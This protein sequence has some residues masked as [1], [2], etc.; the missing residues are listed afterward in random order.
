MDPAD[1]T[2]QTQP[3]QTLEDLPFNE[4]VNAVATEASAEDRANN[5]GP[6]PEPA[7]AEPQTELPTPGQ[8]AKEARLKRQADLRARI[9]RERQAQQPRR[10]KQAQ[11]P[12]QELVAMQRELVRL[13]AMEKSL[14]DPLRV[15]EIVESAGVPQKDFAEWLRQGMTDP[16]KVAAKRAQ[17]EISGVRGEF[18]AML[19]EMLA[20]VVQE[21]TGLKS[22]HQQE[23]HVRAEASAL[24]EL[25]QFTLQS[26]D[27]NPLAA[28][29]LQKRG[30][31]AFYAKVMAAIQQL[32]PSCGPQAILDQLESELED[33]QIQEAHTP[34]PAARRLNGN[35]SKG[36]RALT[37]RA[38]QER[39]VVE[40][41]PALEDMSFDERLAAIKAAP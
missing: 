12:N 14:K 29:Y 17:E 39:T 26:S 34:P 27:I 23:Q 1:Q 10:P 9:E 24:E 32:P 16:V 11:E 36:H 8:A 3:T 21:I 6:K 5:L 19:E 22:A 13:Q 40:E 28:S 7:K 2:P 41:P 25:G 33:A 38:V 18:R 4:R 20:P 15:L 37:N 31:Q 35:S 30:P